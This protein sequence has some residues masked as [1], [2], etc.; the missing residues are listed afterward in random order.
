VR[1]SSHPLSGD[2]GMDEGDAVDIMCDGPRSVTF[3][4]L[5]LIIFD[6]SITFLGNCS[7]TGVSVE[8]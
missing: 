4:T 5:P 6:I 8:L 2:C 1:C 3:L 7:T